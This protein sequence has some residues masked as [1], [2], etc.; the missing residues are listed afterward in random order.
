MAG[1]EG[2]A[3]FGLCPQIL[4]AF[5]TGA[6]V[7]SATQNATFLEKRVE[8]GNGLAMTI[9]GAHGRRLQGRWGTANASEPLDENGF[10]VADAYAIG[11]VRPEGA[12]DLAHLQAG[13]RPEPVSPAWAFEYCDAAIEGHSLFLVFRQE[14]ALFLAVIPLEKAPAGGRDVFRDCSV[15]FVTGIIA[16][17]HQGSSASVK[18]ATPAPNGRIEVEIVER[19]E[20]AS[21]KSAVFAFVWRDGVPHVIQAQRNP[22]TAQQ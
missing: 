5:L 14:S 21:A 15:F 7:P 4:F 17:P 6:V 2:G 20:F 3:M 18:I 13:F 8:L 9:V 1:M 12:L 22:K 19:N 10:L 16:N 11:I